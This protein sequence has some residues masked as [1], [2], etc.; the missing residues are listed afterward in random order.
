MK[1]QEKNMSNNLVSTFDGNEPGDRR[2]ERPLKFKNEGHY[3]E[4]DGTVFSGQDESLA[5]GTSRR[6][7]RWIDNKPEYQLPKPGELL[8]DTADELNAA[9]PKEQWPIGLTG[10][11]EAPWKPVYAVHLL[12]IRDG[13]LFVLE[14]DTTGQRICIGQFSEQVEVM[15]RLR[16]NVLPIVRLGNKPMKTKFGLRLRPHLEIV[17]WRQ[18]S[19]DGTPAPQIE[20]PKNSGSS[21]EPAEI[22]KPVKPM[23]TEEA[24]NDK[25]PF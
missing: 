20:P 10:Q 2:F 6:L 18:I 11:P 12:R 21:T 3:E 7:R 1:Q 23:T 22:G 4:L 8:Q 13:G 9:I 24:L 15:R 25:I 16:G 14:H 19:G 17:A 5:Y